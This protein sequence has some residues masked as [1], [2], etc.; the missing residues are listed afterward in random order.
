MPRSHRVTRFSAPTSRC[1]ASVLAVGHR[2]HAA[3]HEQHP[4]H[5]GGRPGT[6]IRGL[7]QRGRARLRPAAARQLGLP[8]HHLGHRP[9]CCR[10]WRAD[11]DHRQRC[12]P[13]RHDG[14][15]GSAVAHRHHPSQAPGQARASAAGHCAATGP[16]RATARWRTLTDRPARSARARRLLNP[17]GTACG[18]ADGGFHGG[19]LSLLAPVVPA[20][21]GAGP[22]GPACRWLGCEGGAG[23]CSRRRAGPGSHQFHLPKRATRAGTSS[24]RIETG[25]KPVNATG[26]VRPWQ[27]GRFQGEPGAQRCAS[28]AALVLSA[29][30][31]PWCR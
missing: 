28:T 19:G 9:G 5:R 11:A 27:L 13:D 30:E 2:L 21:A 31:E 6:G 20:A 15:D 3:G 7:G 1:R 29:Q 14:R 17:G 24:A 25:G 16:T 26:D 4:G 10:R 23:M 8:G 22:R 18:R 12:G